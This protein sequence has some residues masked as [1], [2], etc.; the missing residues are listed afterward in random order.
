MKKFILKGAI[1]ASAIG[2]IIS[3]SNDDD[4]NSN[5]AELV[6]QQ[7]VVDNYANLMAQN[8]A[9]NYS[10]ALTLQTKIN[11]FIANPSQEGLDEAK[12]AWLDAREPYGQS[13]VARES[14]TAIDTDQS[15][16]TPWG[17][18][19]EGQINAWPI[20]EG[21]IDYIIPGSE[22]YAGNHSG[23]IIAGT[24]AINESLLLGANEGGT[25]ATDK[26]ISTGWHAIEFLLWGQDET[27]PSEDK[28]GQR[29]FTDYTTDSNAERRKTYLS[30]V[31]NI[32]VNDLKDLKDTW[33][34]GGAFRNYFNG[35]ETNEAMTIMLTGT[36]F[37]A[38]AELSEERMIVPVDNTEGIDNSGQELEHSCFADNTHRDVYTNAQ[39]V[40]NVIYGRYGQ[41]QGASFYDLVMQADP[42]QAA[43]LNAAY[44][45]AKS[46]IDAIANNSKP[47]DLLIV[48]ENSDTSPFGPVMEGAVSLKAFSNQIS[49]SAQLLGITLD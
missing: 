31:T 16:S 6:T 36:T 22:A 46:K 23:G 37:I 8:Y 3:C 11:N 7:D 35:L 44:Q 20:D 48:E 34:T 24:E 2:L 32:L 18:G 17:L 5:N 1:L 9:D 41:I 21:Y 28:T 38:G 47:F 26:N 14:G 25:G 40:F 15:D 33:A 13:E 30:T 29:E 43:Q 27:S 4:N 45:D 39:G 49:A 19:S 12:Q 42:N 10:T